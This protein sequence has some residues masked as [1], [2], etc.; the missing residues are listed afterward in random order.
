M[1]NKYVVAVCLALSVVFPVCA[2][3][4][5][6]HDSK[7]DYKYFT[8]TKSGNDWREFKGTH[9]LSY[10]AILKKLAHDANFKGWRIASGQEV[11]A[12]MSNTIE[13][14]VA[15]LDEQVVSGDARIL[16]LIQFFGGGD[17]SGS[18]CVAGLT[19]D[20]M[21]ACSNKSADEDEQCRAFIKIGARSKGDQAAWE[22]H[23]PDK[24][25]NGC[26]RNIIQDPHD[27]RQ[28]CV[29]TYGDVLPD[30]SISRV[31]WLRNGVYL[32]RP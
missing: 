15:E 31:V 30:M 5:E 23:Y 17:C 29:L 22:K 16:Q 27:P 3:N 19:S 13:A 12:L 4:I 2:E 10:E 25:A 18:I 26:E 24:P 14:S 7:G 21:P 32:V 8:D 20:V 6:H 28:P 11:K 9:D 1:F